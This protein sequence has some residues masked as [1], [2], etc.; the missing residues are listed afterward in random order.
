MGMAGGLE[1]TGDA[2]HAFGQRMEFGTT[3]GEKQVFGV[4][5]MRKKQ[6]L[7]TQVAVRRTSSR[8]VPFAPAPGSVF[9]TT[10]TR[11]ACQPLVMKVLEPLSR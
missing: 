4:C 3:H 7:P 6:A 2:L 1:M 9:A 8:L 11:S 10:M 5:R